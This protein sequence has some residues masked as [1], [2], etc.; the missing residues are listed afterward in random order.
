MGCFC[1]EEDSSECCSDLW[2]VPVHVVDA[3]ALQYVDVPLHSHL[4]R[5]KG[6][7]RTGSLALQDIFILAYKRNDKKNS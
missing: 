3:L 7:L 5:D 4:K 6:R 2:K 1:F